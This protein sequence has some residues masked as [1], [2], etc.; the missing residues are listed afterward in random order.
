[1]K[2]ILA[3]VFWLFGLYFLFTG[4]TF[5]SGKL[6]LVVKGIVTTQGSVRVA[7][8]NSANTFLDAERYAFTQNM[9]VGK[10]NSLEFTFDIPYG[11]YAVTCYHDI[12]NNRDLDKST[13]GFPVEPYALSMKNDI[14]WRKPTFNETK[15]FF[16][17][18]AH[19]LQL[20][21]KL[22]KER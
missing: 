4:A 13:W 18:D 9:L 20:E 22:W 15:F 1:M 10:K 3:K 7:I 6:T 21:L 17:N 19:T 2:G 16:N 5:N 11:T 8:Y 14:K 12:N